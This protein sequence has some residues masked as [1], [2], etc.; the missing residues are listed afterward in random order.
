MNQTES[1]IFVEMRT[2]GTAIRSFDVS[3]VWDLPPFR[4]VGKELL[5]R[6]FAEAQPQHVERGDTVFSQGHD[7]SRFFLLVDG[8]I[9]VVKLTPQGDEVVPRHISPG[10]LFGIAIAI[11]SKVYPANAV[12]ASDCK[13]LAWP[14][15]LLGEL[16]RRSPSFASNTCQLVGKRL[17]D[18]DEQISE[19][20]TASVEQRV[21]SSILRLARQ[22]GRETSEGTLIRFPVSRQDI[23][24]MA[25]TTLHS[26]SRILSSWHA[27]GWVKSGRE[28]IILVD[29]LQIIAI[30]NGN[31]TV[32]D[33]GFL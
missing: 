33:V 16:M 19:L 31:E 29:S 1:Q 24:N 12:A 9:R 7:A 15:P 8:H 13:V 28:K 30:A 5:L 18:S 6:L 2:T 21:A 22:A 17:M 10:E 27:K 23:S 11:G 14:S 32:G 4:D 26:V 25:G 20:A 3:V